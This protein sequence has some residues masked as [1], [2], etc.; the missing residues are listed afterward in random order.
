VVAALQRRAADLRSTAPRTAALDDHRWLV[1]PDAARQLAELAITAEPLHQLATRLRKTL[2]AERTHLIL[3]QMEL[4]RRAAAKFADAERMFFTP[5][6][7]QQA[8][9]QWVG[10]CKAGRF[11]PGRP[12][13]DLCCGI[14]GD[15]L[16]MAQRGPV[17]GVERDPAVALLAEANCRE[18]LGIVTSQSGGAVSPPYFA[19]IRL[20][21]ARQ[22]ALGDLAAWH[23]DPDRRASGRRTTRLEA[24]EPSLAELDRL[25]TQN[26]N[27]AVKLAPAT[28]VP[29][30]WAEAAE[31]EWISREG[32]CRQQVAWFGG[33]AQS[34]GQ[35][36]ATVVS[37]T[38][39]AHT[40]TGRPDVPLTVAPQIGRYAYEPDAAV[41]ASRL[42]GD[43]ASRHALCAIA[44]DVAYLTG[45]ALIEDVALAAFEVRDLMPL[46]LKRLKEYLRRRRIGKIEVKK[47][48]LSIDPDRLR[49]QLASD[50]EASATL[51]LTR[52]GQRS[53]AIVAR[54]VTAPPRGESPRD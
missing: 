54:R 34:P 51:L 39:A 18:V 23:I 38:D 36:S 52:H 43:V 42:V 20:A 6:A 44:A 47:R 15:L 33:L 53:L 11:P 3:A 12:V 49:R 4:R 45:D 2:S 29:D 30:R 17:V 48:G 26:P 13:A 21:D 46:E 25:L 35:R 24:Y 31:L 16:G 14:G 50:G 9:D 5:T 40:I 41:L 7:L 32:E 1:G 8:T 10:A 28:V 22:I 37:K 27:A 19:E